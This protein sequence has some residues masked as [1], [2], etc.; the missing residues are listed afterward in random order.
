MPK[1]LFLIVISLLV[2][3]QIYSQSDS[4]KLSGKWTVCVSTQSFSKDFNC[5]KSYVTYEFFKE[6][7]FKNPS[8]SKYGE[9]DGYRPF[10]LGSWSL[11]GDL[12]T[13]DEDDDKFKKSPPVTYKITVLSDKKFYSVGEEGPGVI[14]YTYFQKVD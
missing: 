6:G 2:A 5:Q 10:S 13:I 12:L 14:V 7:R 1:Y 8:P 9:S 3:A 11:K 4:I